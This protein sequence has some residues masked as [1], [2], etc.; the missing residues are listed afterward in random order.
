VVRDSATP[1]PRKGHF[2]FAPRVQ[3]TRGG[4]KGA[5]LTPQKGNDRRA[6]VGQLNERGAFSRDPLGAGTPDGKA[7]F[8]HLTRDRRGDSRTP[9]PHRALVDRQ[10]FREE[11]SRVGTKPVPSQLVLTKANLPAPPGILLVPDAGRGPIKLE[12]R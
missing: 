12:R 6:P 11:P 8:L 9:C 4:C 3:P 2:E 1:F 7:A 5:Y 10:R